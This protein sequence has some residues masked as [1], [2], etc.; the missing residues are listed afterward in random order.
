MHRQGNCALEQKH[1]ANR[2]GRR[3]AAA[4]VAVVAAGRSSSERVSLVRTLADDD[5]DS[6]LHESD[7]DSVERDAVAA[8][9]AQATGSCRGCARMSARSAEDEPKL[10]NQGEETSGRAPTD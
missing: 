1:C 4:V 7:D 6:G 2:E 5:E 3:R 10:W 9:A 8:A